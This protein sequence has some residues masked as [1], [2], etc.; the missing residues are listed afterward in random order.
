MVAGEKLPTKS[1]ESLKRTPGGEALEIVA[2]YIA[3][4]VEDLELDQLIAFIPRGKDGVMVS[5]GPCEENFGQEA[6]RR[7]K[8]LAVDVKNEEE[9]CQKQFEQLAKMLS[10]LLEGGD[11][12]Q[13]L[14]LTPHGDALEAAAS[15]IAEKVGVELEDLITIKP[16]GGGKAKVVTTPAR[17]NFGRAFQAEFKKFAKAL[18]KDTEEA[19]HEKL[20][21][22]AKMLSDILELE[23]TTEE[24]KDPD[25]A[26]ALYE[27][28]G[29]F[30]D[31]I[32][33]D[34]KH[35]MREY[36][37]FESGE[38][39]RS[40]SLQPT[41]QNIGPRLYRAIIRATRTFYEGGLGDG[42]GE[43]DYPGLLGSIDDMKKIE[44]LQEKLQREKE[45]EDRVAMKLESV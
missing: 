34:P 30:A 14:L 16:S 39:L 2:I 27:V 10:N 33:I 23:I 4:E 37:G 26:F 3:E 9:D 38:K 17:E 35:L 20:E 12:L 7:L 1:L 32:K 25:F 19:S 41:L 28:V 44:R 13:W 31:L 40:N 11:E 29:D 6:H 8:N 24:L 15:L 42:K 18:R 21:E 43:K 22:L 5:A 45:K 36:E